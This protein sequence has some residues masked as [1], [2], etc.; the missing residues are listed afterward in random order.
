VRHLSI[1][2]TL[3][4]FALGQAAPAWAQDALPERSQPAASKRP[5]ILLIYTDDHSYKTVGCYPE[6][7]PWVRTPNIDRLAARGIRFTH[8]YLGSWCMPSRASLLTGRHPHGIESMRMKGEYPGSA[9]DPE[10]CPFWPAVFRRHGYHTAQIGKWHTGIDTGFGRDWDH[11]IVWNRPKHPANAGNYYSNQILAIDGVEQP[12][13]VGGYSTDNYTDWACDYIHGKNRTADKPWYL[14]LCYGAVHGPT[15]PAARHQGAYK[16]APVETPADI[17]PPR[18]GK[19]SYLDKTQSWARGPGGVPVM[20]A[21][22]EAFG[23]EAKK[24]ARTHAQW[25]RQVNECALAIDEVVG[26]LLAALRESGQLENTLVVFTADQGF[27]SGE[28]GFRTKLAPYDANYRSPLIVSQPG[29]IPEG[30]V[31]RQSIGAPDLVMTFFARAGLELPWK[32][33]GHDISPLLADPE[34][35]RWPHPLLYEHMGHSYGSDTAQVLREDPAHAV[36][37]NVPWYVAL[38]QGNYKYVRYLTAGEPEEL[39]NLEADPEELTNLVGRQIEAKRLVAMRQATI[40][41]LRRTEAP[42][43]DILPPVG[44]AASRPVAP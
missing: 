15:T 19:P 18:P 37:S 28:H 1:A 42:F 5:N 38:R 2:I 40:E 39:Y 10:Q 29:T 6:S 23:D 30:K 21:S 25:V 34:G 27:S 3:L 16:D 7:Y 22:G 41:E 35:A 17:F 11:Q 14:W 44:S 31:C 36:H 26:K 20:A 9:Y 24:N 4:G 43:V 13:P 8:C 32:M 33:H 12:Q